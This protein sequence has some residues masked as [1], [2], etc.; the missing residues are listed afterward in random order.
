M[1]DEIRLMNICGRLMDGKGIDACGDEM[2]ETDNT[3]Y[4]EFGMSSE[5]ILEI[6]AS[7]S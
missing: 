3:L 1:K 6:T 4:S 5:E 7:K 2:V